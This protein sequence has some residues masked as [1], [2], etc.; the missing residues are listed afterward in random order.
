MVSKLRK[1]RYEQADLIDLEIDSTPIKGIANM[2]NPS[3]WLSLLTAILAV[4]LST[5]TSAE[6][7]ST[8]NAACR[9]TSVINE[10]PTEEERINDEARRS[11]GNKLLRL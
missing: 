5:S 3:L 9:T 2:I 8:R 11:L 6:S 4:D 10:E 7:K 1:V